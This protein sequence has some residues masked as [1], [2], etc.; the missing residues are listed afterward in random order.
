MSGYFLP[1]LVADRLDE[2]SGNL[3]AVRRLPRD[4]FLFA[5]RDFATSPRVGIGDLRPLPAIA[6]LGERRHRVHRRRRLR[7]GEGDEH[8]TGLVVAR[9]LNRALHVGDLFRL[10]A[11]DRCG[12]ELRRRANA[13]A[14]INRVGVGRPE[15]RLNAVFTTAAA[16][17]AGAH[18]TVEVA[19]DLLPRLARLIDVTHVDALVVHELEVVRRRVCDELAVRREHHSALGD[20]VVL[21]QTLDRAARDV[22]QIQIGVV[23]LLEVAAFVPARR[24]AMESDPLSVARHCDVGDAV[25]RVV[26]QPALLLR[27]DVEHPEARERRRG[28][29]RLHGELLFGAETIVA[30]DAVRRDEEDPFAVGRPL[31]VA[32]ARRVPR[33]LRRARDVACPEIADRQHINLLIAGAARRVRDGLAVLREREVRDAFARIGDALRLAAVEPHDEQLVSRTASTAAAATAACGRRSARR[34]RPARRD[35]TETR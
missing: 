6:D 30:I 17:S 13:G 18:I 5:Q 29:P 2:N 25:V 23:V 32:H 33:Q 12:K 4:L 34:R 15:R 19:A 9:H 14:E 28:T 20:D 22:E 27:V 21:R 11:G 24:H 8:A 3:R 1:G 26:R 16:T 10:A 35:P 31:P 7:I